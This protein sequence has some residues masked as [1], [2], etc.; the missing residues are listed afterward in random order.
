MLPW[1]S[2][3]FQY[4]ALNC[5]SQVDWYSIKR[6]PKREML[7]CWWGLWPNNIVAS[8]RMGT[9]SHPIILSLRFSFRLQYYALIFWSHVHWFIIK[10]WLKREALKRRGEILS[11]NIVVDWRMCLYSHPKLFAAAILQHIQILDPDIFVTRTL[12]YYQA[13]AKT[14]RSKTQREDIVI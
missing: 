14:R 13:M 4:W 6:W 5:W 10:R 9:Y 1:Y 8:W 3:T 7:K 11:F 12:I 2:F